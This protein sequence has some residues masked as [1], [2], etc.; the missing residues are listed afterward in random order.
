MKNLIAIVVLS[1]TFAGFTTAAWADEG[2][3]AN[4]TAPMKHQ[5]VELSDLLEVVSRESGNDFLV[6]RR[7]PPEIVVGTV[8]LRDIDY[9]MFLTVLRNNGL[10]AVPSDT[11]VKVIPVGYVRQYQL[12]ILRENDDTVPGDAWVTRIIT[13]E[14]SAAPRLVPLLRPMI[15]QAGHLVADA[16]SNALIVVAPYGVTEG[17]IDIVDEIEQRT[18]E[19]QS[20]Q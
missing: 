5:T 18:K 10:A 14:T 4:Q 17:L 16:E 8:K 6:D 13:L 1:A 7:V 19:R 3:S 9:A 2:Q 20:S 11:A 15:Q 12:P